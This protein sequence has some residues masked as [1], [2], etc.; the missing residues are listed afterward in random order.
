ML[1]FCGFI[2]AR[3]NN[4]QPIKHTFGG[5]VFLL[6]VIAYYGKD[7]LL[8]EYYTLSIFPFAVLIIYL[9]LLPNKLL[10]KFAKYGDP[11]YGIYLFSFPIQQVILY[12]NPSWHPILIFLSTLLII[13]PIAYALWHCVEKPIL[14]FKRERNVHDNVK[15]HEINKL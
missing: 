5:I 14:K 6:F 3:I 11:S 8:K 7:T 9:G 2:I 1:F 15:T 13:T 4:N 10:P 12:M